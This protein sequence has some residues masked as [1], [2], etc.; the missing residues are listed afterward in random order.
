MVWFGARRAPPPRDD[1]RALALITAHG[2]T[3]T[4]FQALGRGLAHWFD[5]ARGVVAYFDTGSAWVAAGEPIAAREEAIAVATAFVD[6]AKAAGRRAVFFATEG[7]LA[8]SPRFRRVGIGEQPVWN[9]ATWATDLAQH[10]SMREQLRRAR[11][12]GV[13]VRALAATECATTPAHGTRREL[14]ALIARWNATRPMASM[15][16]LVDVA[17]FDHADERRL[18]VAERDGRVVAM[19]SLAPVPSRGGWLFEHLLRDPQAPNGTAELLVDGAMRAL[20]DDGVQWVTLGLAPLAGD[21]NGW[22][23][24]ARALARPFFNFSGLSAFKRKLHP[25][26]WEP[27]YLAWPREV[28]GATAMLD[29]LRAFAGGSLWRFTLHSVMRGP[30]PLLRA[31]SWLLVPW[32][33]LLASLPTSPWFPSSVVHWAWIAFDIGLLLTLQQLLRTGKRLRVAEPL[34]SPAGRVHSLARTIAVAV[35]LDALLTLVQ[36]LLWNVP[37]ARH[38]ADAL[39]IAA[40]CVAPTLAAVML[41]GATRRLK[42]L[43]P[44]VPFETKGVQPR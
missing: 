28:H 34:E 12:K 1:A 17:P 11:T 18:F 36:A 23:R 7:V 43:V 25:E 24:A 13:Q 30:A 42:T 33:L 22:L 39:V 26:S 4:A 2:R 41:W 32:T 21:V 19:L 6:A 5:G 20:H 15:Q 38:V 9:P 14:D 37:R 29:G 10:R 27:I 44:T 31:L 16:F 3:G 40:G 35:S 8:A